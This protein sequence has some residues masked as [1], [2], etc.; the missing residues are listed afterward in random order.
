MSIRRLIANWKMNGS[1]ATTRSWVDALRRD[2]EGAAWPASVDVWLAPPS[3]LIA[4]AREALGDL[5]LRV[6]A[7]NC[8]E[9]PHGAFTGELSVGML[10]DCGAQGVIVGHS[11]RRH[12]FGETDL[13]IARK[14]RACADGALDPVLC[15]GETEPE[16]ESGRTNAVLEAQLRLGIADLLP[17]Q[18]ER[19]TLAYE[20]VWAIG[21]GKVAQPAQVEEAHRF[22]KG[23]LAGIAGQGVSDRIPVLYGGSVDPNNAAGLAG[24]AA[25]DGFLVGGASLDAGKF[26]SILSALG[27]HG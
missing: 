9:A 18:L 27:A 19:L 20:P 23:I 17:T 26:R 25:V 13:R 2:R 11:E 21:T 3:L 12:L 4:T 10:I 1:R 6:A 22:L 16:R 14:L 15:V 24:I 5:P 8:H 7:Q